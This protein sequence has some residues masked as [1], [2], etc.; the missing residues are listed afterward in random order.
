MGTDFESWYELHEGDR[1]RYDEEKERVAAAVQERL[2]TYFPGI[3]LQ[4]EM[5]DVATPYTWLHYTRSYQGSSMAW[6]TTPETT[7]APIEKTLPGLSNFY[8]T[9]QWVGEGGIKGALY[10]GRNLVKTFCD[11]DGKQ[12]STA[13][14]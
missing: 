3:S 8:M 10:S 2:E 7:Q 1:R 14:P 12:F 5:T 13:T 11:R 4:V 6:L 9:G